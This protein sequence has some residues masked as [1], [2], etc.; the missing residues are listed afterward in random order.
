MGL[1]LLPILFIAYFIGQGIGALLTKN[2]RQEYRDFT[3]SKKLVINIILVVIAFPAAFYMITI[4]SLNFPNG[5]S[6]FPNSY[7]GILFFGSPFLFGIVVALIKAGL[8][9]ASNTFN[10]K[11]NRTP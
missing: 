6:G 5:A 8:V 9:T 11:L 2:K 4:L 1:I 3:I 7:S 10:K